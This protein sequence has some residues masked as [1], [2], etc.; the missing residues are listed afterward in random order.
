MAIRRILKDGDETLRKRAR[1]VEKITKRELDLLD[2][3]AQTMYEAD[4]CGLAAPQVGVL[5][6]MVVID[7]GEGLHEWINPV[8]IS[9]EG[10]QDGPEGCL[11][12]PGRKGMVCRPLKVRVEATNRDGE[13]IVVDAEGFFARAACHEIDH[14]EGVLYL[15]LMSEELFD[16]P[17]EEEND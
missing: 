9:R 8:I 15:D 7:C 2:D 4:G 1:P 16:D 3:M 5:K 6:R 11:S 13:A 12:V 17:D 14:L 10:E